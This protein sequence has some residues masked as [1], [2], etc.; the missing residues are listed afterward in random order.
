MGTS[1][2][3]SV[4]YA[5]YAEKAGNGFSGNYNDLTHKPDFSKWDKDST[6]S[7]TITG[8][9]TISGIKTFSGTINANNRTIVNVAS[10][11]NDN[12]AVNKAYVDILKR[13]LR[14][15]Q[16]R[17]FPENPADTDGLVAYY[18]FNGNANDESGNGNDGNPTQGCLWVK[19][20]FGNS[21]KALFLDGN[22]LISIPSSQSL[23]ITKSFTLAVWFKSDRL[24]QFNQFIYRGDQTAYADPY[25]IR[26]EDNKI[27][28]ERDYMQVNSPT[29][30]FSLVGLDTSI[31]HFYTGTYEDSTGEM[32]LYI[33]GAL[34]HQEVH[35]GVFNYSTSQM[36]NNIG[37]YDNTPYCYGYIDDIRIYN[38]ALSPAKIDSLF[39]EGGWAK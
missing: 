34:V 1:Q 10:P 32:S 39:H 25:W 4:P 26:T 7:V 24:D 17:L 30:E 12:D 14:E 9:Q 23:D 38:I 20:R 22:N 6:D 29:V 18:P 31:Y 36:I 16:H 28:F 21:S 8:N 15:L 3:L 13:Q 19:D 2:L 37:G 11:I 35:P 5:K 27:R 33:D